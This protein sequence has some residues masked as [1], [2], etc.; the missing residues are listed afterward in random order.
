M[1]LIGKRERRLLQSFTGEP[2]LSLYL[3]NAAH[4]S[5]TA[6]KSLTKLIDDAVGTLRSYGAPEPYVAYIVAPCLR[7]LQDSEAISQRSGTLA[8]FSSPSIFRRWRLPWEVDSFMTV[9]DRFYDRPLWPNKKAKTEYLLLDVDPLVGPA[10]SGPAASGPAASGPAASGP[11]LY[12]G[13]RDWL[14][15][16]TRPNLSSPDDSDLTSLSAWLDP[17]LGVFDKPLFLHGPV[18]FCE[19]LKKLLRYETIEIIES[20]PRQKKATH[21]CHLKRLVNVRLAKRSGEQTEDEPPRLEEWH[22]GHHATVFCRE[23][24]L[25]QG[26]LSD[27]DELVVPPIASEEPTL[28]E[29]QLSS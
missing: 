29:G 28:T 20:I 27:R 2:C 25:A 14:R 10:A 16:V 3:S 23:G 11:T 18:A 24:K 15:F 8:V 19:Q 17:K 26:F 21:L 1:D 9:S 7:L 22:G 5:T 12:R 13:G 4:S 6:S